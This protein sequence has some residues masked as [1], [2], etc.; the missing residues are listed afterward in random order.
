MYCRAAIVALSLQAALG[1]VPQQDPP[2]ATTGPIVLKSTSHAVQLDVFVND[3][4]GRP[5]HSLQKKD[6]AV[7]DNGHPRDLRIFAGE[8]DANQTASSSAT[9]PPGVYSNRIG[10]RDS[11]IV[12]AIVID[13]VPRPE[14]LQ[15][16]PGII[17]PFGAEA[18]LNIVRWQAISAINR[19]A[20]GQ[21]IAIYAA[22]PEL[23]VVQD[24]TS[25]P[26]R[27]VAGLKAFVPP[28]LPRAAGK[29][30]PQTIDAF[31]PPM[32][33]AL[34]DVVARMSGGSG[35]KSVVWISQAYGTELN[36]QAI[37]GATDSTVAAFNDA[38]V[39]LYAVDTRF[40]PTCEPPVKLPAG[41]SGFVDL[42][43][44]Q[45]LDISDEW[46]DYLARAT[47]GQ[48]FSGGKVAAVQEYAVQEYGAQPRLRWGQ[49]Q[50]Q[51]DHGLVS[52][53]LRF[54][55]DDS[56]YAY[57]MG[58]YVPESELDGKI[59]SLSV[60]VPA[61]TKFGLRYRSGYTASA[62]ATAP[63]ASQ[64]LTGPDSN[65]EPGSP[66]NPDEVGIDAKIDI[67]ARAKN[68]LQVSLA[69][70]PETVTRTADGVI[71]LDATFIQTD[72]SGKPLSKI[73]E[74]VQAPSPETQSDMVRY[75]RDMKLVNGAVLLHVRIRD[76]ATNRVGSIAIPIEKQ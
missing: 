8:I 32:L 5:V 67:P 4:Y 41:Q 22:C 68:A 53:A 46:M 49:Y 38:N 65:Q 40:N 58:F 31:V 69:L 70:A 23:S 62:S 20:P 1:A 24:Y 6:F 11:R 39:S 10:M 59:H 33:S 34:R 30:Q 61:K 25:D 15:K 19:L 52:D 42:T 66:L 35:R 16:N 14:G 57:E 26:D 9:V 48:A 76:R 43:C 60:T 75:V 74:T 37:S 73:E 50:L 12:T 63:P 51:S 29:K 56:R 17:P 47:G 13:A 2:D 3:P 45:P 21:T 71:L 64:E 18:I 7:T 36:I 28:P 44:S 54:A 72:Y 55:A 27:L